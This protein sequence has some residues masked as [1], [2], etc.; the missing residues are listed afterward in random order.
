MSMR[1]ADS[2]GHYL[3]SQKKQFELAR[4][5]AS[6]IKKIYADK[7]AASAGQILDRGDAILTQFAGAQG[8]DAVQYL[9]IN[10]L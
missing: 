5:N 1:V 2:D 3:Q 7:H 6:A 8:V 10:S 4:I 9:N